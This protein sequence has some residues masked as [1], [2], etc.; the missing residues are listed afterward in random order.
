MS[1]VIEELYYTY[2]KGTAFETDALKGVNLCVED[3]EFVAV[4]GRTGC[5]KS[6]LLQLIAGLLEPTSGIVC[7]NGD[8]INDQRYDRREL[9]KTVGVVF[10]YPECQLFETTVMKDVAFGLNNRG[11]SAEE[12]E[13]R[14][15]NVL[16]KMGFDFDLIKNKSPLGLSGG[17]KRR[18]A[19]AGVLVAEPSILVL[20]EPIAGLD[21]IWRDRFMELLKELNHKGTTIIV[22]S[23]NIDYISEYADRVIAL[24]DGK[25]V[26]DG[27]I[28]E[29]FMNRDILKEHRI[30]ISQCHKIANLLREK[31]V[32]IPETTI[33]YNELMVELERLAG[34]DN[35]V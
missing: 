16:N 4:V 26:I 14:V 12:K 27:D 21:P 30:G 23:H 2:G 5:G 1:V 20:D 7:I 32:E 34:G 17:E 33:R 13:L 8:D 29:A 31:G 10:Q 25:V 15:R 11:L 3:G 35:E 18:V 6:T 19:I 24:D 28:H 22:I 9:R